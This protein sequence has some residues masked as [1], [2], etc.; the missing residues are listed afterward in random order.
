MLPSNTKR[1]NPESFKKNY[2]KC[3]SQSPP[4]LVCTLSAHM[5]AHIP[6]KV[7][8]QCADIVQTHLAGGHGDLKRSRGLASSR[9]ET[10]YVYYSRH[11]TCTPLRPPPPLL[12]TLRTPATCRHVQTLCRQLYNSSPLGRVCTPRRGCSREACEKNLP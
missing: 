3:F 4:D 2:G 10:L 9:T 1:S 8:R 7:C 5:S 6:Q 11:Q 12:A